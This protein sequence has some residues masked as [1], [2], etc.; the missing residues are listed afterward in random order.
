M[1]KLL[2]PIN[3]MKEMHENKFKSLSKTFVFNPKLQN[4]NF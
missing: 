1:Q 2:K 3:F 4:K